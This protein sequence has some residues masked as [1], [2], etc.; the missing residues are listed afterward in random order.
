MGSWKWKILFP[1]IVLTLLVGTKYVLWDFPVS[2]GKRVGNLTKI[3]KKGKFWFT[4]TWEGTIDE[5]SGDKLTT[6]F[7]VK[8]EVLGEELYAYEGK[9]VVLYY[10]EHFLG[11]PRDTKYDIKSW[12]PKD[13]NIIVNNT[14]SSEG[15]DRELVDE[16]SKTLFCTLLGSLYKDKELYQRVKDFIKKENLYLYNQYQRCNE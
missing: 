8:S 14:S 13:S 11:W 4:K 10:E 9:Q 15:L 16:I 3:S 7:S 1:V 6:Q 12:K 2:N 5:G